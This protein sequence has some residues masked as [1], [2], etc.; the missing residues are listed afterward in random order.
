MLLFER[1]GARIEREQMVM[2][3]SQLY[4][5]DLLQHM[6]HLLRTKWFLQR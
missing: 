5:Y 6:D 2:F 4:M 1:R 3:R